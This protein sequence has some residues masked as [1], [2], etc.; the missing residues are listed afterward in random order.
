MSESNEQ[1]VAADVDLFAEIAQRL[2]S[3]HKA[4][5]VTSVVMMSSWRLFYCARNVL[6]NHIVNHTDLSEEEKSGA[7]KVIL[8]SV[9]SRALGPYKVS[10][11]T[12]DIEETCIGFLSACADVLEEEPSGDLA[13][14]GEV[15]PTYL[16]DVP[17]DT[18][19]ARD[20]MVEEGLL[21]P[22]REE[23]LLQDTEED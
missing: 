15:S 17:G 8:D 23:E 3:E 21:P 16:Q 2:I 12:R 10:E 7:I 5:Q 9:A 11:L 22:A 19:P 20:R 18:G 6:E 4:V 14:P 1:D 13:A